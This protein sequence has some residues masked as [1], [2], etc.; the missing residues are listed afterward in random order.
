MCLWRTVIFIDVFAFNRLGHKRVN[1]TVE[2]GSFTIVQYTTTINLRSINSTTLNTFLINIAW[3][4]ITSDC[5]RFDSNTGMLIISFLRYNFC[6]PF[7]LF[8]N[9]NFLFCSQNF[10]NESL[11]YLEKMY[12]SNGGMV[13]STIDN[14]IKMDNDKK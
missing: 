10:I 13:S 14:K 8:L 6:R 9:H 3:F 11:K 1:G 4:W 2:S 5:R 12:P 7:F